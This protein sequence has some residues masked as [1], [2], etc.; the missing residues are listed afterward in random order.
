[1]GTM[2]RW[3]TLQER[4][5]GKWQI[6]L[7][8]L[9]LV[10]LV[11]AFLRVRPD[12][13]G[14][15]LDEALAYL[16]TLIGGG[17]FEQAIT[18]GELMLLRDDATEAQRAPIHLRL[19][20]AR[21]GEARR[22]R[23]CVAPEGRQI[24][25]GYEH[26]AA[27]GLALG[28]ADFA[29]MGYAFECRGEL[30]AA[31]DQYEKAIAR[32]VDHVSDVRRHALALRRAIGTDLEAL[33]D[34]LDQYLAEVEDHRLDLRLWAVEQKLEVLDELGR[35]SEAS[36]LLVRQADRF[37]DSDQ[38]HAFD[39]LQALLL[40]KTGNFQQAEA[41]LRTLRN[42]MGPDDEVDARAGWL[43]GRVVLSDGGPQRPMEALSFFRD[44][45]NN[46][47]FGPYAVASCIGMAESL[48]LLERDDAAVE[49]YTIA[50]EAL[51]SLP[52]T[53]VVNRDVLRVSLEVMSESRRSGGDLGPAVAYA[54][55]AAQLVNRDEVEQA[56]ASLQRLGD[57]EAQLAE[58]AYDRAMEA[59]AANEPAAKALIDEAHMVFAEAAAT[60]LDL[61]KLNVP[62]ERRSAEASW[63][64]A[65]LYAR[66]NQR[67]RAADLYRSFTEERPGHPLVPRALLRIG[68]L[69]QSMG[70]LSA[71]VETYQ[72]CY[73]RYPRALDGSRTLV[74]LAQC[75][76]AMGPE[77]VEL[78]EKTLRVVLEESEVF[79]PQAPEFAD[80][81]FLLGD[82]LNRQG[83]F[84]RAIATLEEA[85]ERYPDDPRVLR[86]T[87]LLADSYVKSGLALK[88]EIAE[89]AS[90]TQ[91][92][93]MRA[94]SVARFQSAQEFYRDL[95]REYELRDAASLGRLE[96]MSLRHAYLYEA[97]CLFEVG[98]YRRALKLYEEAAG[99]Y[100][101][102]PT[103]LAAYV[104][105]INCHVFLGQP[106]EARAALARALI[107]VDAIPEGAFDRS[108]SSETRQ[109][110]KRYF[111]WLGQSDLF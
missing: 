87:S 27:F 93:R 26:A 86:A 5:A 53:P 36:T 57:L 47:P 103:G 107:L 42:R 97:D 20:R 4:I 45:V 41:F 83:E 105:M 8:I 51:D 14:L 15:P 69:R 75:Y 92:E 65:E 3:S 6:P 70:Q 91:I 66:A 49:A 76:L 84:E 96:A 21:S 24:V 17:A 85:R 74:P 30:G 54:R 18:D 94:E 102:T 106:R 52:R 16:D 67:N 77:Q 34:L 10:M 111:E 46:H 62:N 7:F 29:N 73:R 60:Y 25:E 72:E 33:N 88:K 61:A 11:G 55:L 2:S 44:V 100:K 101:D 99:N 108:V 78:A 35:L 79:T 48:A 63:R 39:Y 22:N 37:R 28:G 81:L 38:R 89:A 110:W 90:A 64:A 32:G 13:M 95:I 58:Q 31:L 9:S 104:Q 23:H 56:T 19:A 43:L 109:D 68:Q 12:P 1:M 82:V 98:D 50:I 59:R 80:A 40:H 71:A